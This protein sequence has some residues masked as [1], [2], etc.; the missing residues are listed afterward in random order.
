MISA[1]KQK[2]ARFGELVNRLYDQKKGNMLRLIV[3]NVA[4]AYNENPSALLPYFS[5]KN[6]KIAGIATSA[7]HLLTEDIRPMQLSEYGG[8]G[9]IIEKGCIGED[10][11]AN[12]LH[13]SKI[14]GTALQHTNNSGNALAYAV[15]L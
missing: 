2:E 5:H 4:E 10:F 3:R 13:F 8:L 11:R 9:A 7:Y 6:E 14:S 15:L 12:Q 1:N